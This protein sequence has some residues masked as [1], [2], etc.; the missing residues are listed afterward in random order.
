M[1]NPPYTLKMTL[2]PKQ[3][4]K[5]G[6][7]NC[8]LFF[9]K[10]AMLASGGDDQYLRTWDVRSGNCHQELTDSRWGQITNLSLLESESST[11]TPVLF[12]G[13]GRGFVSV[14][15][16]TK[17]NKQFMR[18]SGTSIHPFDA[19]DAVETQVLDPLNS[20][21]AVG[22]FR[23]SVKAYAVEDRKNLLLMYK[24]D[25]GGELPR[26]LIFLNEN[27]DELRIHTLRG[28]TLRVDAST[29][30]LK[31]PGPTLLSG[32]GSVAFSPDRRT[33]V[34]HNLTKDK[35]DIYHPSESPTPTTL[36]VSA[37]SGKVKGVIFAESG[38]ILVCG[39]D[40]GFMHVFDLSQG[41]EAPRQRHSGRVDCSTVVALATE[42]KQSADKELE[43]ARQLENDRARKVAEEREVAERQAETEKTA[44]MDRDEQ[45]ARL[46]ALVKRLYFLGIGVALF[47]LS[48]I[49]L[50]VLWRRRGGREAPESP[51]Q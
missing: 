45:V 9:D 31:T 32:I 8:L 30:V 13:T 49:V 36:T 40:D 35:F 26:H 51:A 3:R 4:A 2:V 1:S 16:W 43:L 39:G 34:V 41:I 50:F 44:K 10:G 22:S 33:K 15:P 23:G 12:V 47:V 11:D 46:S 5:A 7:L 17:R 48:L 29:G 6:A 38:N 14:Y 25:I 19:N 42:R 28:L 27:N 24:V 21:F 37:N 20:R 18:H